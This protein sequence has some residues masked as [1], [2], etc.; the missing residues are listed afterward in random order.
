MP[1]LRQA[2]AVEYL[3]DAGDVKVFKGEVDPD[4]CI[5]AVPNGGYI[6]ALALQACIER[7]STMS[8]RDP[9]HVTAH[10]LRTTAVAPFEVHIR[11]L[12]SGKGFTNVLADF[13]QADQLKFIVHAIF[14][15]MEPE[16]ATPGHDG[17]KAAMAPPS[18]YARHLPLHHHPSNATELPMSTAFGFHQHTKWTDEPE[19]RE[20]NGTRTARVGGGG[21]QWGTW[22]EL[23]GK[24]ERITASSLAFLVDMFVNTPMIMSGVD[25]VGLPHS[26]FP[27]MM[28][29]IEFKYPIPKT[30]EYASRTVGLYSKGNYFNEPSGHHD[31]YVEVWTAPANI[32]EGSIEDGWRDKQRCLATA[33]QMALTV[34]FEVNARKAARASSKL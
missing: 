18:K 28:L 23:T 24:D 27:T 17:L 10:Y 1:T 14:G 29:A 19:L 20:E 21:V 13:V 6:L 16:E 30:G 7:Q 4:W 9:I 3:R 31:I 5:G 25:N 8:H 34:P 11:I 33:T 26:W 32:G 22:F 12:R 2:I 15:V